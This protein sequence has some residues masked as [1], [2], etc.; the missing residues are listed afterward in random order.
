MSGFA[1]VGYTLFAVDDNNNNVKLRLS[2][3]TTNDDVLI[4]AGSNITIDTVTEGGFTI[5]AVAGAGIGIAASASDVLNVN[6]AE[7]GA[8]D[9][10]ADK[11][12]FYDD[13]EEKLTYLKQEL[14]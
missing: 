2:D 14:D 6:N 1:G 9:A 5:A 8:V 3:G 13:S 4:T 10:T 11:I 12:V 7:I